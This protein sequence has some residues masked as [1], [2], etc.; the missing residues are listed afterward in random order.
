MK[1]YAFL[2][3]T[4]VLTAALLVGCG[5]TNQNKDNTSAPTV[6]PTNEEIWDSTTSTTQATTENTLNTRPSETFDT[7]N[8]PLE[9]MMPGTD[10]TNT[11]TDGTTPTDTTT[12]TDTARSRTRS[13][14][15]AM[16]STR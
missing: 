4:I 5:C 12:A 15:G 6:L 3:L 16:G 8:G 7:G 14:S 11:A 13:A 1:T 2:A 9:D 10:S